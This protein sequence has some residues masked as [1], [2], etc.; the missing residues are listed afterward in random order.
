MLTLKSLQET[1]SWFLLIDIILDLDLRCSLQFANAVGLT[2]CPGAPRISFFREF[3]FM[4][5][6]LSTVSSTFFMQLDVLSPRHLL[7]DLTDWFLS[8]PIASPPSWRGLPMLASALAR[9]SPFSLLTVLLV[10]MMLTRL[11]VD[12]SASPLNPPL[13]FLS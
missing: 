7:L 4:F 2:N 1:S 6:Q 11:Y 9:S 13:I 10:L 8:R 12:S 5:S 3:M